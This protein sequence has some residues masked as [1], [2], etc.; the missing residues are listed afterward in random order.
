M[1]S[2]HNY[3][4]VLSQRGL[5]KPTKQNIYSSLIGNPSHMK[6][7]RLTTLFPS[8]AT[9]N[10]Q[11]I[12]PI[13]IKKSPLEGMINKAPLE[14]KQKVVKELI[15]LRKNKMDELILPGE[16]DLRIMNVT[17]RS[18]PCHMVENSN[19]FIITSEAMKNML[20]LFKSLSMPRTRISLSAEGVEFYTRMGTGLLGLVNKR[21]KRIL[22]EAITFYQGEFTRIMVLVCLGYGCSVW[23]TVAPGVY[24]MPLPTELFPSDA[25]YADFFRDHFGHPLFKKMTFIES[26]YIISDLLTAFENYYPFNQIEIPLVEVT[27]ASNSSQIVSN[28]NPDMGSTSDVGSHSSPAHRLSENQ[29]SAIKLGLMMAIFIASGVLMSEVPK[30]VDMMI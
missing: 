6:Y 15:E 23:Y 22:I 14:D 27:E 10:Q 4:L 20:Y 16:S 21:S 25:T 11:K 26:K 19:S 3:D 8:I 30:L 17:F 9:K 1:S 7:P 24:G 2:M 13:I 28:T 5:S 29:R 18:H 12:P